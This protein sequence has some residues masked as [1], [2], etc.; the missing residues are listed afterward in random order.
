MGAAVSLLLICVIVACSAP[1]PVS[2][3]RVAQNP[4]SPVPLSCFVQDVS[5]EEVLLEGK[6]EANRYLADSRNAEQE[7]AQYI[8][9]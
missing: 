4:I 3:E 2:F 5:A 9:A 8:Y 6:A 1:A 7:A